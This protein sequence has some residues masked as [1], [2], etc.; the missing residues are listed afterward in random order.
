MQDL[1]E[2]FIAGERRALARVIS[3]VE[4]GTAE[5]RE[6][7]RALKPEVAKDAVEI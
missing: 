7:V 5:G 3:R 6:F 2:R 4:N 1:L